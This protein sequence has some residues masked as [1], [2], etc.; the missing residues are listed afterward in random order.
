MNPCDNGYC[1]TEFPFHPHDCT[2]SHDMNA[3]ACL[4]TM[5]ISN[6]SVV[7]FIGVSHFKSYFR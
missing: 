2:M 7:S 4:A 1:S 3:E 6:V 5:V